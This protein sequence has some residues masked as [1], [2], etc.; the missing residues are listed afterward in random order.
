MKMTSKRIIKNLVGRN[1]CLAKTFYMYSL[2]HQRQRYRKPPLLI[3]TMGKVGSSTVQ[4]SLMALKLDMPIYYTHYLTGPYMVSSEENRKK[5][6]GTMKQGLIHQAWQ[7]PYLR[8]QIENDLRNGKKRSGLYGLLSK[9][10]TGDNS[11][12]SSDRQSI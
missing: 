5:Y 6:F 3:F 1:Y 8:K 4:H 12:F 10:A 9:N 7:S 11:S 2:H